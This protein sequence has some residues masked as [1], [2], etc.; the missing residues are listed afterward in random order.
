MTVLLAVRVNTK[1]S[2]PKTQ[3][4]ENIILFSILQE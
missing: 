2:T 4:T 1:I 3:G